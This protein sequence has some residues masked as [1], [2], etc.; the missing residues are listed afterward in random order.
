MKNELKISTYVFKINICFL[1]KYIISYKKFCYVNVQDFIRTV[2]KDEE[3]PY[4]WIH[5]GVFA[6]E[7]TLL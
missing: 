6:L 1:G 5:C 3:E 2:N 4:P 7:S